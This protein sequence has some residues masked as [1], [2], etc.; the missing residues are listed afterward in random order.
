M[1]IRVVESS[2]EHPTPKFVAI[3]ILEIIGS[4]AVLEKPVSREPIRE[5]VT[6]VL[7]ELDFQASL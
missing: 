1:L 5:V 2:T 6:S 3:M 7:V 4:F